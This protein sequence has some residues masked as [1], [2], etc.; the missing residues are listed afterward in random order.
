[1]TPEWVH[2]LASSLDANTRSGEPPKNLS[3]CVAERARV[4]P[5]SSIRTT[6]TTDDISST[7]S[8]LRPV[9]RRTSAGSSPSRRHEQLFKACALLESEP[10]MLQ[11]NPTPDVRVNVVGDTHGQLHDALKLLD[12]AGFPSETNWFVFNGDF[13]DR[14]AW[15]AELAARRRHGVEGGRAGPRLLAPRE[16]RVRVL[17][18]GVRIQARTPGEV[19]KGV[20][21]RCGDSSLDSAP[22]CP[23]PPESAKRHSCRT[24]VCSTAPRQ[25]AEEGREE[26]AQDDAR[27]GATRGGHPERLGGASGRRGSR[28]RGRHA[29]RR[30]R[31]VVHTRRGGRHRDCRK[32]ESRDR[33][34]VRSGRD[35]GRRCATV[36]GLSLVLRSHEGPDAATRTGR[37]CRTWTEDS[38]SITT[39]RGSESCARC[40]A[41]RITRSSSRRASGG[42]RAARATFVV[43]TAEGEWATPAPVAFTAAKPRPNSQP[44]YDITVGGS[45][46]EGPDGD[47][48]VERADAEEKDGAEDEE[49]G[50]E[51]GGAAKPAK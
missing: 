48:R 11:L 1:M 26:G 51:N 15:G 4:A 47:L 46:E 24:A 27:R 50:K 36:H 23:S 12:L 34:D 33:D 31:A 22:R 42:I 14:G 32:R 19:R 10:T 45:D 2:R 6:T 7:S 38:A 9:F 35:G 16:P 5:T 39:S 8:A 13:V 30:G 18:G 21:E 43:L 44:Y 29:D 3:K 17:H 49:D 28:R 41:R 20:R 40:S 25:G 37:T